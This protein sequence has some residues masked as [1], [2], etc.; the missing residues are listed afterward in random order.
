M[1]ICSTKS[2]CF[3]SRLRQL[4]PWKQI[5]QGEVSGEEVRGVVGVCW[6]GLFWNGF[7]GFRM[8]SAHEIEIDIMLLERSHYD[9]DPMGAKGLS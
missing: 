1:R 5:T 3:Y 2:N 8:L 7:L 9:D 4:Y 6:A